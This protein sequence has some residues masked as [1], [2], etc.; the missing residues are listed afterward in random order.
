[1]QLDPWQVTT[2]LIAMLA[3]TLAYVGRAQVD[4]VNRHALMLTDHSE[5]LIRIEERM[6]TRAALKAELGEVESRLME[7]I[8][9]ADRHQSEA[10]G[11]VDSKATEGL[12]RADE[13]QRIINGA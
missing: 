11:R 13:L 2:G 6:L 8:M 1:M 7:A 9:S 12:K 4:R 10:I 3:G 5:R